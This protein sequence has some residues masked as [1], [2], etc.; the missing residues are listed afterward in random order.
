MPSR[1]A[2]QAAIANLQRAFNRIALNGTDESRRVAEAGLGEIA[3][4]AE[5]IDELRLDLEAAR[6]PDVALPERD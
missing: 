4:L 3:V 1:E 2:T 6:T 5:T